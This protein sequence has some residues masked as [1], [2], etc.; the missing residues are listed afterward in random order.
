MNFLYTVLAVYIVSEE[1]QLAEELSEQL[2]SVP[3]S[4]T[5]LQEGKKTIQEI[6]NEGW[7]GF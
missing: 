7:G 2:D 3:Q 1:T 4:I 5:D 6:F